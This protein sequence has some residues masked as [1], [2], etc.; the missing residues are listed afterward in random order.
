MVEPE[1]QIRDAPEE[2]PP[3]PKGLKVVRYQ[4]K[5]SPV[6]IDVS[7]VV[8]DVEGFIRAELLE[9]DARLHNPVQIRGGWGVFTILERLR[10]VGVELEIVG[11][12]GGSSES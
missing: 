4:P 8:T 7:S 5:T 1:D 11:L 3:L 12:T 2:C 10:Q 6:A 9:L